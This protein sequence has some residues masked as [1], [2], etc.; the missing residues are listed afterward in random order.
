MMAKPRR[1]RATDVITISADVDDEATQEERDG[2]A[3][4][5]RAIRRG[6]YDQIAIQYHPD[7]VSPP[8]EE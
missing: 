3:R 1:F 2:L 6:R 8:E 5:L 7:E 4:I